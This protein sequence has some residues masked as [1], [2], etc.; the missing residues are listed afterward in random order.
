MPLSESKIQLGTCSMFILKRSS[1]MGLYNGMLGA[2]LVGL[3]E[4][5]Y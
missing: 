4:Q 2:Q 1:S 3:F 5:D